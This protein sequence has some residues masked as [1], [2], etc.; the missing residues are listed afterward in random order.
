MPILEP[1]PGFPRD[2]RQLAS[3]HGFTHA[4]YF[5]PQTLVFDDAELLRE[6]CR[7]NDCGMYGKF[8]TCPPGVGPVKDCIAAIRR[9]RYGIVLQLISEA[10]SYV[11]N[12]ELFSEVVASFN[13]MSKAL[14]REVER[15]FDDVFLLGMSGCT[16]CASCTY[17]EKK[18]RYAKEM[19]PCI[20]G[21][22]INVF[23]LWRETGYREAN[24]DESDFYSILLFGTA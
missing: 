13:E 20:S 19:V 15:D 9:Y 5:D 2:Y 7:A 11:F 1:N 23:R 12:P 21:H 24:L 22:C 18:C 17:P 16:F 10:I 6:A 4:A 14:K 3:A 8:W